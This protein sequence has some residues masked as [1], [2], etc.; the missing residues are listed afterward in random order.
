M[1]SDKEMEAAF[2][3]PRYA[4]AKNESFKKAREQSEQ[5]AGV[6]DSPQENQTQ[7]LEPGQKGLIRQGS[8]R[9]KRAFR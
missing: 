6:E 9:I 5:V 3:K 2:M 1:P 4:I 7:N 8:I